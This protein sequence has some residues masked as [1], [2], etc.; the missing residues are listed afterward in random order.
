MIVP[1]MPYEADLLLV[2]ANV[3]TIDPARP[4]AGAVAVRGDRIAG[5]YD[6][7]PGITAATVTDLKGATLLPG[8]HDAH[9]HMI[10][11]GLTLTEA[12]LRV[13]SL[14]EL[15]GRVEA[16]AR[17]TPGGEWV[18]GSGYDHTK[19][20]GHP[21]RDVLDRIAPGRRVWLRHT[22][23]HMCVVNSLVLRDLGIDADAPHVDGGRVAAYVAAREQG[24]L[25]VRVELMVISDAFHPLA[26]HPADGIEAGI[27]LGLRT[28]FGDD[29]LR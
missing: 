5:V 26:A 12:D 2:N 14:E 7:A 22:S 9:N 3:L 18:V 13:T 27:D 28:G 29:W 11:F 19:T 10:G 15:Y 1:A 16:R 6:G 17:T 23:G 25:P 24:R 21:H 4:R 8:F 20:G